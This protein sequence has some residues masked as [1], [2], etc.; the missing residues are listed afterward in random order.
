MSTGKLFDNVDR[1]T[2][3]QLRQFRVSLGYGFCTTTFVSP[4]KTRHICTIYKLSYMPHPETY[5]KNIYGSYMHHICFTYMNSVHIWF[6]RVRVSVP[7]TFKKVS[8][9]DFFQKSLV[10]VPLTF[11]KVSGT[12][13]WNKL[14][15][16]IPFLKV[17]GPECHSECTDSKT[18][19]FLFELLYSWSF[20]FLTLHWHL[21]RYSWYF[22]IERGTYSFCAG[23][24]VRSLVL[25][26]RSLICYPLD[27]GAL[28]WAQLS[29][30]NVKNRGPRSG[31][32]L[33]SLLLIE[34]F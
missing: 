30:V 25:W 18:F 7:L 22:A 21:Y 23:D 11:K 34:I 10:S 19:F 20:I 16:L 14:V 29:L 27:H 26:F 2:V 32:N 8:A 12:E 28:M 6:S 4:W 31:F 9:S 3:R 15:P 17:T 5:M 24:G 1:E 33:K 13:N